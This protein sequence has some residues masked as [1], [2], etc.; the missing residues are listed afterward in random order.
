MRACLF[1]PRLDLA[2]LILRLGL[3]AIFIVHGYIKLQMTGQMIPEMS[4]TTQ[5][6]VGV[7][8]LMCGVLLAFGLLSRLAA[9]LIAGIQVGAIALVSGK[10]AL[11]ILHTRTPAGA[12]YLQVGPEYNLVLIAMSLAVVLLGSG[13]LSLDHML[14]SR[15]RR[16]KVPAGAQPATA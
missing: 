12:D 4:A 5:R 15:W 6:A 7:V 16:E 1:T 2:S 11:D 3:A 14:L 9:L 13:A 10:H 8:E